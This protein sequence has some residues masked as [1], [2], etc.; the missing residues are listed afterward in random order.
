MA[1]KIL[2][3]T[4]QRR[5]LWG[6]IKEKINLSGKADQDTVEAMAIDLSGKANA[7][8]TDW[9]DLPLLDGVGFDAGTKPGYF[10]DSFGMV[11]LRGLAKADPSNFRNI[12]T[13]PVGCRPSKMAYFAAVSEIGVQAIKVTIHYA[14]GTVSIQSPS[15]PGIDTRLDGI[16]FRAEL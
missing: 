1:E 13:L 16:S 12:G 3:T 14:D 6:V 10:K 11:H 4:L 15:A 5:T 9:Q 2:I 7:T 8:Q